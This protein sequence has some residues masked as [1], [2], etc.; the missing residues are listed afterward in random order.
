MSRSPSAEYLIT[1]GH[2]LSMDP[3]IGDLPGGAVHVRDGEIVAVGH[4]ID[5]PSAERIDATAC[6]VLPG[7]VDTHQHM[8]TSLWRGLSHDAVGYFGLHRLAGAYTPEDHYV[9]VRYAAAEA[10]NAGFTTSHNWAHGLRGEADVDAELQALAD[11]GIRGHFGYG[12]GLPGIGQRPGRAELAAAATTCVTL[13]EGRLTLGLAIHDPDFFATGVPLARELGLAT[14]APHADFSGH[15]ELLGPDFVYT[16]GTGDSPELIGLLAAKGT[17]FALCPSTDPLVG[18]GHSPLHD[19]LSGGV[20][21][22]DIGLSV[23]VSCQTAIDPFSSMR[24]LLNSARIAQRPG[25][26]FNDVLVREVFGREAFEPLLHPRTALAIATSNGAR[27]LGLQD[28]TGSLTPGKRADVVL[29][30]TDDFNMLPLGT[31]TDVAALVVQCG[32]TENVDTVL[33]DGRI[34]KRHRRLVTPD[35]GKIVPRAAQAQAALLGR[36]G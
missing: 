36:A 11:S 34:V 5:A 8:W 6:V 22:D 10:L 20:L 28:V 31:A 26:S 30:R 27:V 33:V 23:D 15:V 35:A 3:R 4:D 18:A 7:F 21:A 14:I 9:A 2:V 12:D 19:L 29:V 32:Q 24:L 16:H 1:G 25:M 13:G 17:K